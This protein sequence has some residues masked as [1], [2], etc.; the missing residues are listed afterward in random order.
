[1]T[2]IYKEYTVKAGDHL[3]A[4][5]ETHLGSKARYIEIMDAEGEPL[6]EPDKLKPGD[7][8]RIPVDDP[9]KLGPGEVARV[10]KADEAKRKPAPLPYFEYTV[11]AGD[12]LMAIAETH[13]GSKARY[14]E[15]MD[16]EGEPLAD[17]NKLKP[18]DV[19]RIPKATDK[20]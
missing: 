5:A 13:L 6:A 8:L 12:H 15:I 19:L 14:L 20:E 2:T 4:I 7:V 18:G 1:M 11:K 17:P 16:A 3:M 10:A 9:A